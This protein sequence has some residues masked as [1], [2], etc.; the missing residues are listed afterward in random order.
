MIVRIMAPVASAADQQRV[1]PRGCSGGTSSFFI[2]RKHVTGV[3]RSYVFPP[4]REPR[5][6]GSAAV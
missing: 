3:W 2:I 1:S 5:A 4:A 6:Q